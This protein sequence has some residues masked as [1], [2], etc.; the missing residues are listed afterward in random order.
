M[1]IGAG[2]CGA[3]ALFLGLQDE[4]GPPGAK[5]VLDYQKSVPCA[6]ETVPGLGVSGWKTLLAD[7]WQ[8]L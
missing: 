2:A 1:A 7:Y 8:H 5:I 6:Q 4:G 3:A